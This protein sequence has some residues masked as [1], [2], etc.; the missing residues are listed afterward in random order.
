MNT[1]VNLGIT[2]NSCEH[3]GRSFVR[4]GTLVKHFCE[5]KRRWLDSDRPATRI[6]FTAWAEFYRTCQPS[7]KNMDFRTFISNPYYGAFIKF[8]N[9]CVDCRVVNVGGYLRFLLKNNV[10]IDDWT[11]DRVYT[12]YLVDFLKNEDCFEAIK[13]SV[14]ALLD[15]CDTENI[16]LSDAFRYISSNKICHLIVSGR[17][18]PWLLYQSDAGRKFL[19]NINDTQRSL[20]FEYIDP[21]KWAIKFSKETDKIAEIK[22]ILSE[23]NFK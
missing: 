3:C 9:Y 10:R 13:R 6:A 19:E 5:Q 11:S 15:L 16:Q 22:N 2:E 20:I 14:S 1:K 4:P 21:E 23:I 12:T 18:S 7:K 17:I 8:G